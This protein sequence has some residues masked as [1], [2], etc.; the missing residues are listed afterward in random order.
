MILQLSTLKPLQVIPRKAAFVHNQPSLMKMLLLC[1]KL[2]PQ[3]VQHGFD[4]R[5]AFCISLFPNSSRPSVHI[6]RT[7]SW[8]NSCTSICFGSGFRSSGGAWTFRRK[9]ISTTIARAII[10]S[11]FVRTF[12]RQFDL[13][14]HLLTTFILQRLFLNFLRETGTI[15]SLSFHEGYAYWNSRPFWR[16]LTPVQ[17]FRSLWSKSCFHAG[18]TNRAL[19]SVTQA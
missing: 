3:R 13:F 2:P 9:D 12:E 5:S 16:F 10:C 8:R 17:W 18:K 14:L 11:Y 4:G 1:W 7:G 6:S 15:S 19:F